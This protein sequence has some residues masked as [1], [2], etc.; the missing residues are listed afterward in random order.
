MLLKRQTQAVLAAG[1]NAVEMTK[2]SE[3]EAEQMQ[4]ELA[5]MQDLK[6]KVR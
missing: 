6:E 3:A 1:E 5:D 2:L 4:K